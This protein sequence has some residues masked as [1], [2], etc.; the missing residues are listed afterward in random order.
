MRNAI[1][2][3]LYYSI[4]IIQRTVRSE[5]CFVVIQMFFLI[6]AMHF[7]LYIFGYANC[8]FT[9]AVVYTSISQFL[10]FATP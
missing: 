7:T 10:W 2:Y 4:N 9:I 8:D 6:F 1:M 5:Q 3:V